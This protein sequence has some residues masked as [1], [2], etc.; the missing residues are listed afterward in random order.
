[1]SREASLG[2]KAGVRDGRLQ[3]GQAYV[4][5]PMRK[6]I[7]SVAE[8]PHNDTEALTPALVNWTLLV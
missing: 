5:E 4:E 3:A 1:M 6:L 8:S 7:P 2:S